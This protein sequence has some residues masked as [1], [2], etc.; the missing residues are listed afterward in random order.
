[1]KRKSIFNLSK[2]L[3]SLV[4]IFT[5]L[6]NTMVS[7]GFAN[8]FESNDEYK[9]LLNAIQV[10]VAAN[11]NI[12]EVGG[13]D[14]F[15]DNINYI[16][17]AKYEE[18]L[19]GLEVRIN[20]LEGKRGQLK[21]DH[22]GLA[23]DEYLMGDIVVK[24]HIV[25]STI[26]EPA[27]IRNMRMMNDGPRMEA[28]NKQL[29]QN[30][31]AQANVEE[32]LVNARKLYYRIKENKD[33]FGTVYAIKSL[34]F[35]EGEE[36]VEES[37]DD[38]AYYEEHKEEIEAFEEDYV[39]GLYMALKGEVKGD[40]LKHAYKLMPYVRG[41][42]GNKWDIIKSDLK[43]EAGKYATRIGGITSSA[44]W[45]SKI[46][47]FIKMLPYIKPELGE[48]GYKGILN[49]AH[50]ALREEQDTCTDKKEC[51][52]Y[53]TLLAK[54]SQLYLNGEEKKYWEE[55][56]NGY[57]MG[58]LGVV[59]D[60]AKA[61]KGYENYLGVVAIS[62][63]TYLTLKDYSAVRDI[64]WINDHEEN[65][66]RA[67]T[68]PMTGLDALFVSTYINGLIVSTT[69]AKDV[70]TNYPDI[71]FLPSR[72]G[73]YIDEDG[74]KGNIWWD[75]GEMLREEGS[76]EAE[77]ILV[78]LVA[79]PKPEPMQGPSI[80]HAWTPVYPR[81]SFYPLEWNKEDQGIKIDGIRI[82]KISALANL[83]RDITKGDE[84]AIRIINTSYADLTL[85]EEYDI[86]T[87]LLK[88][89]SGIK[90]RELTIGAVVNQ[91][92]LDFKK[93][94]LY[95]KKRLERFGNAVDI[96]I[97]V[98]GIVQLAIGAVKLIYK[99]IYL[100]VGL[101]NAIKASRM[102]AQT[103]KQV[104]FIRQNI[105]SI[106]YYKAFKANAQLWSRGLGAGA[107]SLVPPPASKPIA[108]KPVKPVVNKAP[109]GTKVKLNGR[110][111]AETALGKMRG[112]QPKV[113]GM[114]PVKPKPGTIEVGKPTN[115]TATVGEGGGGAI[116][117]S[118]GS[119]SGAAVLGEGEG[120]LGTRG[121]AF[122]PQTPAAAT[123]DGV[124]ASS[125][126]TQP[127]A[128]GAKPISTKPNNPFHKPYSQMNGFERF[129]ITTDATIASFFNNVKLTFTG[130]FTR[131]KAV[132]A[133]TIMGVTNVGMGP[134]AEATM[135]AGASKAPVAIVA[136]MPASRALGL[137]D[138]KT[139]GAFGSSEGLLTFGATP[140]KGASGLL[141]FGT[142]PTKSVGLL[143]VGS[144]ARSPMQVTK[145]SP[146]INATKGA[147]AP[148]KTANAFKGVGSSLWTGTKVM[149]VTKAAS[150][151][152]AMNQVR[153]PYAN[154][155]LS[156]K[157]NANVGLNSAIVNAEDLDFSPY[158]QA[159]VSPFDV[160]I[161]LYDPTQIG[162][163]SG[164]FDPNPKYVFKK[165]FLVRALEPVQKVLS[166]ASK[167]VAGTSQAYN[168]FI[169]SI[170]IHPT[171]N[172]FVRAQKMQNRQKFA[173]FAAVSFAGLVI[174][175]API[176]GMA[177]LFTTGSLLLATAPMAIIDPNFTLQ[178]IGEDIKT[179]LLSRVVT[180]RLVAIEDSTVKARAVWELLDAEGNIILYAKFGT[181]EEVEALKN[182][183]QVVTGNNLREKY[184]LLEIEYP[185][186]V[187]E[188][189]DALAPEVVQQIQEDFGR[190]K[191]KVRD[192][193][194]RTTHFFIMTPIHKGFYW[195]TRQLTPAVAQMAMGFLRNKPI[196][197]DEWKQYRGFIVAL[198]QNGIKLEDML[199]NAFFSRSDD[200]QIVD[201]LVVGIL[202]LEP[203]SKVKNNEFD[204]NYIGTNFEKI[205]AKDKKGKK[206]KTNNDP[207]LQFMTNTGESPVQPTAQSTVQTTNNIPEEIE[208]LSHSVF[209]LVNM[210][211]AASGFLTEIPVWGVRRQVIV[212][213]G[214]VVAGAS[215]SPVE[216]YTRDDKKIG[217]AKVLFYNFKDS[218]KDITDFALLIPDEELRFKPLDFVTEGSLYDFHRAVQVAYPGTV[219]KTQVMTPAPNLFVGVPNLSFMFGETG[220][221]AS[222]GAVFV[223]T[224]PDSFKV[225]GN[226]IGASNDDSS[227]K[228]VAVHNLNWLNDFINGR[229]L[230]RIFPGNLFELQNP[231][232]VKFSVDL[233]ETPKPIIE[234]ETP[235]PGDNKFPLFGRT[236]FL[237]DKPYFP[238]SHFSS[239]DNASLFPMGNIGKKTN[240]IWMVSDV[241]GNINK[242]LGYGTEKDIR[243]MHLFDRIVK[244]NELKGKYEL[245]D[246]EYP[247]F[248]SVV[249]DGLPSNVWGDISTIKGNVKYP[250]NAVLAPYIMTPVRTEGAIWVEDDASVN[251]KF[252]ENSNFANNPI[253]SEEWD[254]ILALLQDINNNDF[255]FD[256]LEK[257]VHFIRNSEGKLIIVFSKFKYTDLSTGNYSDVISMGRKF[258]RAGLKA[259]E[260][261]VVKKPVANN[262]ED[263]AKMLKDVVRAELV[264]TD[265]GQ[266]L[267]AV[268]A[269]WRLYNKTGKIVGYLKYGTE[270]E[271]INTRKADRIITENNL[272]ER[273]NKHIN[274][275][276]SKILA[277]NPDALPP[278]ILKGVYAEFDRVKSFIRDVDKRAQKMFILSPV[279]EDAFCWGNTGTDQQSIYSALARLGGGPITAAQWEENFNFISELERLG[280]HYDDIYNNWSAKGKKGEKL[281]VIFADF[282]DEGFANMLIEETRELGRSL[283]I[284]GLKE[285]TPYIDNLSS[286]E[287]SFFPF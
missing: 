64:I 179:T 147:T 114:E 83:K 42:S 235:A 119:A 274:I 152:F 55:I 39:Y 37:A 128:T 280:V 10:D 111:N 115:L 134:G 118:E 166:K 131:A 62:L 221:G 227:E 208:E 155:D 16:I 24:E 135:M 58:V 217:T 141:T 43:K 276:Y 98:I 2:K 251:A 205:G 187:S 206:V 40:I 127:T 103:A 175:S 47:Y 97:M 240:P 207:R 247:E 167:A 219:F 140:T 151:P 185:Q 29:R 27:N 286:E 122:K 265:R 49:A 249:E 222:G 229:P 68:P 250:S 21:R 253:T 171:D 137:T 150:T 209:K 154:L 84:A 258:E 267:V 90:E 261:G 1:M 176:A 228:F 139:F 246:L 75:I 121:A 241:M 224:S 195:S 72:K 283:T 14:V 254:E 74:R 163:S 230:E 189:M 91:A 145:V 244:E 112:N 188:S 94:Q 232:K 88:K 6:M 82:L 260:Y 93:E 275:K 259:N 245:V 277:D 168:N 61:E 182:L 174:T 194:S 54:E 92:G 50:K 156:L 266:G 197:V 225:I 117:A 157:Y 138:F 66:L 28:T 78:D 164:S 257:S 87:R 281:D 284:Y 99:G 231:R 242:F 76:K 158:R 17:A 218:K 255:I 85:K 31:Q 45:E 81:G 146:V 8:V 63:S 15:T 273:F 243:A 126:G 199:N 3:V 282:E 173:G 107:K 69:Y 36:E 148:L 70:L 125:A 12:D 77:A 211:G 142:T 238:L 212:T 23:D 89:Y 13:G 46:D 136:E 162:G 278:D 169:E 236:S 65:E 248:I 5:L 184:N 86:D 190:I 96:V 285:P 271:I 186:V 67:K 196:S 129:A 123:G 7:T 256:D 100:G 41:K 113:K 32:D 203:N 102:G 110:G 178:G 79:S 172:Y 109:K 59:A 210:N 216:I 233:S 4:V 25:N 200:P 198:N 160:P 183:D 116:G 269:V 177:G 263:V 60:L 234:T 38:K 149:G 226:S 239:Y 20:G 105:K 80:G 56:H 270:D 71:A 237:F 30:E 26:V 52:R 95:N 153:S 181:G 170:T 106:Q 19:K 201:K 35:G 11:L 133:T 48:E 272:V 18:I 51:E 33:G 204:L 57:R 144:A 202:D 132:V 268:H 165:P 193:D 287:S 124:V 180:A 159:P 104:A 220:P 108:P 9:G 34:L 161:N 214:H 143:G 192:V 279:D 130:K 264:V 223:E 191:S 213:A 73:E 215:S 44:Q 262:D 22:A 53:L 252:R 120:A 101:F